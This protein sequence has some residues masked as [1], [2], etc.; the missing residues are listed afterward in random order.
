MSKV[1]WTQG[2]TIHRRDDV[3]GCVVQVK[4]YGLGIQIGAGASEERP[5]VVFVGREILTNRHIV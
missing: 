1:V 3:H 5:H 4:H 2:E